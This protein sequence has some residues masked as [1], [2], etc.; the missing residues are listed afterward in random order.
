MA[1]IVDTWDDAYFP[2]K[3]L[4]AKFR[5]DLIAADNNTV[6]THGWGRINY[7][8]PINKKVKLIAEA[9]V[10]L[11]NIAVDTTVYRFEIGGMENNRIDWYTSFPG[12]RFL[13]HGSNNVWVAKLS[14]RYEFFHNHFLTFTIAYAGLDNLSFTTFTKPESFYSGIG[15]KYSF[16]SMFGPLEISTDYSFQSYQNNVFISLGY[17]F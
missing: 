13:E 4:K 8:F 7:V 9:F 15:L 12:L 11:A 16:N 17:W 1:Y 3:G 10:G 6:L 2:K 5:A 14:P